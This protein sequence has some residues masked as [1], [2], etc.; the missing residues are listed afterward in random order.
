MQRTLIYHPNDNTLRMIT[1]RPFRFYNRPF[2]SFFEFSERISDRH[3]WKE[4]LKSRKITKFKIDTSKASECIAPQRLRNF[5]DVFTGQGPRASP[6][7]T[8]ACKSQQ[9]CEADM[10]VSFQQ[11]AF[12]L[13]SFADFK[14]LFLVK[15]TNFRLLA[16]QSTSQK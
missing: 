6:Q 2:H 13:G 1:L 16:L 12:K 10:F 14:P 15:L 11:I 3:F 7:R 8:K 5:T 4:R 9:V